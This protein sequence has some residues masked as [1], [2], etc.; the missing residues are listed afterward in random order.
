[1]IVPDPW[2]A[3]IFDVG[4]AASI[5]SSLMRNRI[6]TTILLALA[7]C[8]F[9]RAACAEPT[10]HGT[11][12]DGETGTPVE[13]ATITLD[14]VEIRLSTRDGLFDFGYV[15]DG[16]HVITFTHISYRPLSVSIRWPSAKVPLVVEL[17]TAQFMLEEIIVKGE[18]VP[19]GST[20]ISRRE[21]SAAP[22]NLANDPLRTVQSQPSCAAGGSD[23]LSKMAVRG[24]DTEEHR[25]FF[26]GYPL[27]HYAHVGGFSGV[28]YDDM[29]ER[30]VL[31][32]G[33]APIQYKG[34][35][36]GVVSLTP[37]RPDTSFLSFRY[38]ITS[39][40]GGISRVV[41]PSLS[42]QASAKTSFF[43][44]PVYQE[45]GVKERSFRDLLGRVVLSPG[46]STTLTATLLAATDSET[47]SNVA[48]IQS[49]RET[50]SILAGIHL[51]HRFSLWELDLRPAYSFYDSRDALSWME[52]DREH[53]LHEARLHA[54]MIRRGGILDILISGEAGTVKHSG[55]GGVWWDNPFSA[56]AECR[57]MLED[58]ATLAL[59]VGGSREPWTRGFEPEA[60]GSIEI[61]LG[62][63]AEISA[64]Y[65]RSHQSP[66]RFSERRYFAS[67][68][69]DAG[70]LLSRYSPS[71]DEAP[72]VRMDQ[73]SV[74]ATVK[75]PYRCSLGCS[76]FGR[77][78]KNLL[79][80]EWD[81][82]PGFKNVGSDGDGHGYGYEIVLER[83]DPELLSMMAAVSR[84]R[85]WKREGTLVEE[86]VGDFDRPN[87]WQAGLSAKLS[88]HLRLSL[89]FMDVD[90]RPYT[91]YNR[92]SVPPATDEINSVRLMRFQR[93]DVKL[94]YG[95][96]HES[97]EAEFFL[98]FVN[99]LNRENIVMMFALEIAPGE[100][101]SLPYGGTAP[102]PIGGVTIR[103]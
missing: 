67:L 60:Y 57:L 26:D 43:N 28:V 30:T 25:V 50:R 68:P 90:G 62:K 70:D 71:W 1:M 79:T 17:E 101:I 40:A 80:W 72:A 76:G 75:L 84:A 61:D 87:S 44:L 38:D 69:I 14:G 48:G 34:N 97:F 15:T 74:E 51:A 54:E 45:I 16:D 78:Y 98:D 92:T 12:I 6:L 29:L 103:W 27:E 31:V 53:Q 42:F 36:S 21:M 96:D 2:T 82:F 93:L 32:P 19:F 102:F 73:A 55:N 35:L 52:P 100:F 41:T 49:E 18:R 59:A 3:R 64:G 22:G 95:Y 13:L 56:S 11:V 5:I 33:A 88:D 39:M 58:F 89:R 65:R 63:Q 10:L 83:N 86:R 24:G 81:E 8:F 9:T 94:V 99:V 4:F 37:A 47:G 46:T 91:L 7:A 20:S 85:V 66:F 77:W 23:F